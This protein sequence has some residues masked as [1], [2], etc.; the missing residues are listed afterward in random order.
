MSSLRRLC[1]P[2]PPGARERARVGRTAGA[3]D[4]ETGCRVP[5]CLSRAPRRTASGPQQQL[6]HGDLAIVGMSGPVPTGF[7]AGRVEESTSVS[8][9]LQHPLRGYACD[10]RSWKKLFASRCPVL[11]SRARGFALRGAH[12]GTHGGAHG[13]GVRRAEPPT[14]QSKFSAGVV[15]REHTTQQPAPT[16]RRSRGEQQQPA[17]SLHS[18]RSRDQVHNAGPCN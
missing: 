8:Q 4:P 13:G 10:P 14:C 6:G 2:R 15:L 11:R 1:G 12:G 17:H 9:Q 16:H 5:S 7:V 3:R 18:H